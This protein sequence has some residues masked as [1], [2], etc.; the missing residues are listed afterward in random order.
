MKK[1]AQEQFDDWTAKWAQAEKDGIFADAPK[2]A[3]PRSQHT[4]DFFGNYPTL[5]TH[6]GL[7]AVDAEYWRQVYQ[8]SGGAGDAPDVTDNSTLEDGGDHPIHDHRVRKQGRLYKEYFGGDDT[9]PY[10]H[11]GGERAS[12]RVKSPGAGE[13]YVPPSTE[14]SDKKGEM[15]DKAKMMGTDPHPQYSQSYGP[16]TFDRNTNHTRVSPGL[17]AAD[18]DILKL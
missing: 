12:P 11:E 13:E 17:A 3:Q 15:A 6:K 18:K 14:I 9:K 1:S 16:D 2:P 5:D 8:M 7:D 10:A 4:P